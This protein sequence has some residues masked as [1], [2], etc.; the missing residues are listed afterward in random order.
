MAGMGHLRYLAYG[1]NL[2][3]HRMRERVPSAIPLGQLEL[4]GWQLTF[5]K[6]GRDGSA[7]CNLRA[8]TDFGADPAPPCVAYGV[9]YQIDTVERPALDAAEDLGR[10]YLEHR[11]QTSDFGEV[12]FYLATANFIDSSLAPFDWYHALVLSGARHHDLPQGHIDRIAAVESVADPDR[13]RCEAA[14]RIMRA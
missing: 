2:H 14:L 8:D 4:P 9:V 10:G 3:P 5:E 13:D 12:F 6:R 1:S 11:L 7:K